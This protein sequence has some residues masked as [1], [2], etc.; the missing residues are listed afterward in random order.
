MIR[1]DAI[2][3]LA[4][5]VMGGAQA[6]EWAESSAEERVHRAIE[7]NE[8]WVAEQGDVA[9][10]WV[11]I[12]GNRVEGLYV[13]PAVSG[14]GIGAALLL[15]A[16]GRIRSAGHATAALD[17][18]WNADAF[19]LRRGYQAQADRAANEG[20]PMLKPLKTPTSPVV[21]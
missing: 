6:R 4:T 14:G 12:A 13:R 10:S 7:Q 17:A 8:V 18:S 21:P 9:A 5:P 20:R 15:H 16:E 19:Y 3:A 2:L 11:E 1:R